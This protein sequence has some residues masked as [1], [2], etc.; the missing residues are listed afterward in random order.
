VVCRLLQQQHADKKRLRQDL[1]RVKEEKIFE[2]RALHK[3]TLDRY[4][5]EHAPKPGHLAAIA[6]AF[7]AWWNPAQEEA[8]TRERAEFYTAQRQQLDQ[9]IKDLK[10]PGYKFEAALAARHTQQRADHQLRFE[11]ERERYHRE[12]QTAARL[13][14][15]I[16]RQRQEKNQEKLTPKPTPPPDQPSL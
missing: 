9:Q 7:R 16:E 1:N 5:R 6:A 3:E 14:A 2:L 11:Q 13:L 10:I 8:R 12:E 4:D 15:E